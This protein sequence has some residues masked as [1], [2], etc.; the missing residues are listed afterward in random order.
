ME[1][2]HHN[3]LLKLP[4]QLS[5]SS[6]SSNNNTS[7]HQQ[8]SSS[9]YHHHLQNNNNTNNN[10]NNNLHLSNMNNTNNYTSNSN[11][12]M[13]NNNLHSPQNHYQKASQNMMN[14][15][16]QQQMIHASVSNKVNLE[17]DRLFQSYNDELT[18]QQQ[19]QSFDFHNT[20]PT[21]SKNGGGGGVLKASN[22]NTSNNNPNNTF[23]QKQPQ[24][25]SFNQMMASPTRMNQ[26]QVMNQMNQKVPS[27]G[28][29][30]NMMLNN[31][32]NGNGQNNTNYQSATMD[33][34]IPNGSMQHSHSPDTQFFNQ[35][36]FSPQKP[37]Q[38]MNM[39]NFKVNQNQMVYNQSPQNNPQQLFQQKQVPLG[40]FTSHVNNIPNQSNSPQTNVNITKESLYQSFPTA[41]HQYNYNAQAQQS[42]STAAPVVEV[43]STLFKGYEFCLSGKF[44]LIQRKFE[45]LILQHGGSVQKSINA[46]VTHLISTQDELQQ[47]EK[48]VKV[49]KAIARNIPIITEDF[50][51]DSIKQNNLQDVKNYMLPIPKDQKKDS[52]ISSAD[53]NQPLESHDNDKK[54]KVDEAFHFDAEDIKRLK[55]FEVTQFNKNH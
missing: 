32:T 25:Q 30:M 2:G 47:E 52:K 29:N 34:N 8:G 28:N 7:Q 54:R 9:S 22:A 24:Q 23:L 3:P 19:Y 48:A 1:Q 26:T 45:T 5:L 36:T 16:H 50:I 20:L 31:S 21:S 14:N 6:S 35:G 41:L 15:I 13:N 49:T 40:D 12:V 46:V 37:S 33:K 38:Q 53:P 17:N 55:Q 10:I 44:T 51:Q 27:N 42:K 11:N 39:D 18:P 4:P 43:I